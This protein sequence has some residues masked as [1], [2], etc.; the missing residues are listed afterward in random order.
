MEPS[1]DIKP[2]RQ[3]A[4][5]AVP[6][7]PPLFLPAAKLLCTSFCPLALSHDAGKALLMKVRPEVKCIPLRRCLVLQFIADKRFGKVWW[8]CLESHK[9]SGLNQIRL[10]LVPFTL[11]C[12]AIHV[13]PIARR[14]NGWLGY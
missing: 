7:V 4:L 10:T 1:R 11:V 9:L 6:P 3:S 8:L 12:I 13:Q 2:E 14:T 5:A